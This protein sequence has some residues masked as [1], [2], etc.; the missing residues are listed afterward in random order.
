DLR[1]AL[2]D[3]HMFLPSER[4]SRHFFQPDRPSLW[5]M[6]ETFASMGPEI[7]VIK[8]GERG[9]ALYDA[10]YDSRWHIPAYPSQLVDVTGAGHSFA[11]GFIVGMG[12]NNDPIEAALQGSASASMTIEG[13]GFQYPLESLPGLVTARRDRLREG[14]Q[15]G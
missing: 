14:I 11:G 10:R 15:R 2:Q 7:V 6:A 4:Q 8:R 9:Q 1:L 5:E 12:Q 13:V 3:I